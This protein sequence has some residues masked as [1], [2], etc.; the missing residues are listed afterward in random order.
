MM[1]KFNIKEFN[2]NIDPK[3]FWYLVIY[4][5]I[6]FII[7][8]VGIFP[9]YKYN[10]SLINENKELKYQIEEQKELGPIYLTLLKSVDDKNL[11]V[12]PSPDKTTISRGEAGKFQDDFRA[13]AG[14]AGLT[15][16]SFTPDLS[17]LAGSSTSLLHN[18]VLKG[19]FT[20]F[21][22]MLIELGAIP[23]L[24][25][26]EEISILQNPDSMEFRMKIWIA[27]K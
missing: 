16:I 7:I 11:R 24:D 4:G 8:L 10:S 9:L 13:I 6:I 1:K 2:I 18:I 15:I 21:R 19:E 17:T 26:I 25:R 27:L 5:G 22:K 14:K 12:L 20:N 3:Y 23:Y